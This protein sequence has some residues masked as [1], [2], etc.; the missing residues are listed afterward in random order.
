MTH[1]SSLDQSIINSLQSTLSAFRF[2]DSELN[3]L[4]LGVLEG[5][6]LAGAQA[7]LLELAV[8]TSSVKRMIAGELSD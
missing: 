3:V 6:K 2:S 8:V 4:A 5:V 7:P 1:V